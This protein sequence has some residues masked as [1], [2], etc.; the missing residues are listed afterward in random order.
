[1]NR[2]GFLWRILLTLVLVGVLVAGGIAL[3]RTGWAQGY[4]A[5]VLVAGGK[6][7]NTTPAL[8]FYG[9]YPYSYPG[10]GFPFFAPFGL[11]LGI[12]FFLLV[13]FLFTG[14]F[15]FWGWRHWAHRSWPGQWGFGSE[16]PWAGEWREHRQRHPGQD[17]A[18]DD[19]VA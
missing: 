19:F 3:Y 17:N 1:M 2:S 10:F 7:G 13:F 14:L 15:R 12:G 4:Q 18:P 11:C 16:A 8:P 5:A 9:V 6:G